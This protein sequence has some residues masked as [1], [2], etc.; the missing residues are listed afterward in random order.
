MDRE[1][2]KGKLKDRSSVTWYD[3]RTTSVDLDKILDE[4]SELP[5]NLEITDEEMRS[6][7]AAMNEFGYET[8]ESCVGHGESLPVIYFKCEDQ[9][10]LRDLS[11][12]VKEY[13]PTD[14]EW[15]IEL[16]SASPHL[17][18]DS[19]LLFMMNPVD[20][21]GSF[22]NPQERYDKSVQDLDI[23]GASMLIYFSIFYQ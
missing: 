21:F 3:G 19:K 14:E 11:Y 6:V 22:S 4:Y 1:F 23:I 9:D 10:S 2:L 13:A 12:I 20:R 17:H 18:P 16:H 15:V 5:V 7:C 8:S